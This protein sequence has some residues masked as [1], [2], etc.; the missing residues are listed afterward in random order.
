MAEIF[1]FRSIDALIGEYH[2]LEKQTIYFSSPEELNDPMEGLRD[3]VWNGDEIVWTNFFKHYV[4]C[5]N[6]SYFL[7]KVAKNST[8]LDVGAIP[9][10]DRWDQL[11]MPLEQSLFDD[12]WEKFCDLPH[13]REIIEALANTSRKIKYREIVYYLQGI[14]IFALLVEIR[15][16]YINHGLMTESEIPQL[17]GELPAAVLMEQFL[18]SLKQTESSEYEKQLGALYQ[19]LEARYDSIG[20]TIQRTNRFA[21]SAGISGNDDFLVMYD[22]PKIYVEQLE[23]LLWP[24]WYT[25]CF[26]KRDNNSSMWAKYADNHRGAC[27]IFESV[28]TDN[29]DSLELK[30]A[31]GSGRTMCFRRVNYANKPGEIDF[32]RTI[33][34][35]TVSALKKLWYTDQDGNT[36]ECAAH[37][38]S[39]SNEADWR[40]SYW[41]NFFR[42]VIFKTKDWAYEHEYRLILEDGLSEFSRED[43][44][45]LTYGFSSLKGIIFGM[46]TSTEDKLKIIEI[47][48]K[49]CERNS[50]DDF[51]FFQAHYSAEDGGIRKY[52]VQIR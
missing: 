11:T 24:K 51:K 23:K 18:K 29:L 15:K 21:I 1:R 48:Q 7:F 25:A 22:F 10:L 9:I 4:F 19:T 20:L 40:K 14:Q 35:I 3:I 43:D 33:C 30:R 27:L 49:K 41:R 34:R 2:E 16:S 45:I 28:I 32:F 6:R 44:R 38:K 12:I 37:I 36:S 42:D 39:D 50:Q 5:L 46:R 17:F 26:T 8:R 52:E 31:T 47:I 13:M